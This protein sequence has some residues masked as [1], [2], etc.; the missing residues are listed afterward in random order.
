MDFPQLM[1][2]S[3]IGYKTDVLTEMGLPNDVLNTMQPHILP[4]NYYDFDAQSVW[5]NGT[6]SWKDLEIN[7]FVMKGKPISFCLIENLFYT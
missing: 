3:Q 6:Y 7:Q 5:D 2:C 4:E 1:I